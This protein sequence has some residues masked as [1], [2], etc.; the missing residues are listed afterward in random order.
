MPSQSRSRPTRGASTPQRSSVPKA[1]RQGRNRGRRRYHRKQWNAAEGPARLARK[2]GMIAPGNS[3]PV[4]PD[5]LVVLRNP[6]AA[7]YLAMYGQSAVPRAKDRLKMPS[8]LV[9]AV[10]MIAL[11]PLLP[12]MLQCTLRVRVGSK[13]EMLGSS[14][15]CPQCLESGHSSATEDVSTGGDRIIF[16]SIE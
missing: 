8:A 14:K 16:Q 4:V 5:R 10:P 3:L 13:L 12:G 9:A 1:R 15:S 2:I 7:E 11:R 6:F